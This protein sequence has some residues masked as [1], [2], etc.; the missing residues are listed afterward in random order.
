VLKASEGVYISTSAHRQITQLL[1][2]EVSDERFSCF[3]TPRQIHVAVF[4]L[5]GRESFIRRHT[6]SLGKAPSRFFDAL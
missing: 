2:G 1:S 5:I 4:V 6:T 3:H